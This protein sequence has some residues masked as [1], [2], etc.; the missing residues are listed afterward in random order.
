MAGQFFPGKKTLKQ[1]TLLFKQPIESPA[2]IAPSKYVA[3]NGKGMYVNVKYCGT[4]S[5]T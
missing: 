1:A 4:L 3:N 2:L 5:A